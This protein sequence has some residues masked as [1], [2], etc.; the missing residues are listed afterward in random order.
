MRVA[1][2]QHSKGQTR[3]WSSRLDRRLCLM[4]GNGIHLCHTSPSTHHTRRAALHH[5][6]LQTSSGGEHAL[7]EMPEHS[8]RSI[9]IC[10]NTS[11]GLIFRYVFLVPGCVVGPAGLF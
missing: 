10:C 1:T 7:S 5:E 11:N 2:G 4:A 6:K 8:M 3:G 9:Y